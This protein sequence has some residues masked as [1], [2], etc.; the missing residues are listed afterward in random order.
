MKVSSDRRHKRNFKRS[1]TAI[2]ILV[3][4]TYL[5]YAIFRPL[6][7]VG[8]Q[9]M[10]NSTYPGTQVNVKWPSSAQSSAGATGYGLVAS[11]GNTTPVPTAST[12]KLLTALCVL[13]Q[14]PIDSSNSSPFFVLSDVDVAF[15]N[16]QVSQ[17]GSVVKV[18]S[19]EKI[20]E[21]QA[22]QALLLPSANNMAYSLAVWAYGSVDAYI[23]AASQ[24]ALDIGMTQTTV[25]DPSGLMTSTKSTSDDMAK[26]GIAAMSDPIISEIVSQQTAAIPV[27]GVIHNVDSLLG[28]DGIIGIKTGNTDTAG[29]CFIG[30][31]KTIIDGSNVVIVTAIMSAKNLGDALSVTIPLERDLATHFS[32]TAL[33]T[34]NTIAATYTLPWSD[35]PINALVNNDVKLLRW[36]SD[37]VSV[38][39]NIEQLDPNKKQNVIGSIQAGLPNGNH[40]NTDIIINSSVPRPSLLWRITHP[41]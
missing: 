41:L 19:G 6:P 22:L 5:T 16:Q 24:L 13:R 12:I 14:K 40:V 4:I 2:V 30:A 21:Y 9:V 28:I 34:S 32:D 1:R 36:N 27:E 17:G 37:V 3:L 31:R 15:Y 20:S 8:A 26:L 38:K 39:T 29:G 33:I 18:Q 23:K 35:K 11:S 25:T 7:S 10:I